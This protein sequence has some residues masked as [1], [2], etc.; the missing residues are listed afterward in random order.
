MGFQAKLSLLQKLNRKL[1][2]LISETGFHWVVETMV[3]QIREGTMVTQVW[4]ETITCHYI[5]T[6]SMGRLVSR[7]TPSS[8]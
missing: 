5:S 2:Y 7:T 8:L 3:D 6:N 4:V 1:S